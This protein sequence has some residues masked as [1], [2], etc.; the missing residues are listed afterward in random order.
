MY[1]VRLI[2][3]P[4]HLV[5]NWAYSSRR[6]RVCLV[7]S[8]DHL[9]V[10]RQTCRH[11]V[12]LVDSWDRLIMHHS[13]STRQVQSSS[14]QTLGSTRGELIGKD[15]DRIVRST[16]KMEELRGML[17]NAINKIEAISSTPTPND[18]NN[19]N[20]RS[21]SSNPVILRAGA[22]WRWGDNSTL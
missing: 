3:F 11:R 4:D 19:N 5:V 20:P 17:Q 2:D 16:W 21:T 8:P 7:N 12:R 18:N 22:N 6:R 1:R 10:I 14:C 13:C 15:W 9:V